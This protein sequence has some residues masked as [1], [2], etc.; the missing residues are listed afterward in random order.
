MNNSKVDTLF[1]LWAAMTLDEYEMR[2]VAVETFWDKL[3]PSYDKFEALYEREEAEKRVEH[4]VQ[5]EVSV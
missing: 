3:S 2:G 1:F 4:V 5:T